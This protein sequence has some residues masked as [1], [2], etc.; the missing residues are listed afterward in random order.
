M[1]FSPHVVLIWRTPKLR[2]DKF[3]NPLVQTSDDDS[4]LTI[5]VEHMIG[6]LQLIA[7]L[8][9]K[10]IDNVNQTQVR[11]NHAYV[12]WKGKQ[13]FFGFKEGETYVKMKKL[14]KKKCLV[15]SIC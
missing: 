12:V 15:F 1:R 4:E 6:K 11:Q 2:V 3:L 5:M 10:F 14:G 13:M 9:G 8:D 7:K